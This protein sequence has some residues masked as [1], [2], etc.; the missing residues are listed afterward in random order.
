MFGDLETAS[1][2]SVGGDR[3]YEPAWIFWGP[4]VILAL[5]I[6]LVVREYRNYRRRVFLRNCPFPPRQ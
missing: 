1:N 3:V 5:A 6:L 2:V 4:L